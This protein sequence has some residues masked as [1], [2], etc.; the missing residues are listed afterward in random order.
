MKGTLA[1]VG[2]IGVT[3]LCWGLY[4]PV[5]HWGQIAMEQSRLRP[6]LCV[7]WSYFLIG[8]V[9]PCVLLWLRGEQGGWTLGGTVWGLAA[10]TLG[11]VGALGIIMA[12]AYQG[13]PVF[14]MPLV[15][16]GAPVMNSFLTMFWSKTYRQVGPLFLAGLIL[17]VAGG[18]TVLLCGY[19]GDADEAWRSIGNFLGVF[20]SIAL[21][22]ACWGAYG[23]V[24]HKAQGLMRQSRLRPFVCVGV[25]YFAVAVV[26]PLL[27]L[28][29]GAE[30]ESHYR[31]AGVLWSLAAGA[32]GAVGALGIIMAFSYGGKPIYVMPLVF[33]G[34]PVV[35]A[36][37]TLSRQGQWHRAGPLFYAGL[38]L[39]IVGAAI[40]LVF[41]PK[42]EGKD[43]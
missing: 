23:P 12:F 27:L 40:V 10:G 9:V 5:L 13:R 22:I 30:P 16:G 8:V 19:G 31:L 14:V 38:I 41:A 17:V 39:V 15:F 4:G 18:V 11:A 25:A 32:V 2:F 7:G 3:V 1:V 34:A 29:T 28:S 21:A 37:V 42:G 20:G 43:E 24:L 6:F 33:S 36:F 35:N 26:V